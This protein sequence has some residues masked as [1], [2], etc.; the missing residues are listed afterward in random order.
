MA[1]ASSAL[2]AATAAQAINSAGQAYVQSQ[3]LRA[4]ADYDSRIAEMNAKT[5]EA[6]ANDAT[7]RGEKEANRKM[8]ETRLNV[9]SQRAA[10][11][12]LGGSLDE[13]STFQIQEETRAIGAADAAQIRANAFMESFGYKS[14]ASESRFQGEVNKITLKNQARNTLI[15]GGLEAATYGLKAYSNNKAAKDKAGKAGGD[16]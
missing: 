16:A 12:G 15:S 14:K 7:S 8:Q 3:A 1:E 6:Q 2:T 9:G 5:L 13:G 4:K 10:I 11:A